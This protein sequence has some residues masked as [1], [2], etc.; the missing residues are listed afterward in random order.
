[1]NVRTK[2]LVKRAWQLRLF[3]GVLKHEVLELLHAAPSEKEHRH[4]VRKDQ[5]EHLK[6]AA[7]DQ[8]RA[9]PGQKELEHLQRF[10]GRT[11]IVSATKYAPSWY[12]S[13]D[14]LKETDFKH[15]ENHMEPY[16]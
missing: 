1:M 3:V 13:D 10:K 14:E 5:G 4:E 12:R 11:K 15:L 2:P 6:N 7:N 9:S 8:S 16:L